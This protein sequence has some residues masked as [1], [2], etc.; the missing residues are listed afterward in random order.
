MP[1]VGVVAWWGAKRNFL[2]QLMSQGHACE[3]DY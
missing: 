2:V 3:L 1:N